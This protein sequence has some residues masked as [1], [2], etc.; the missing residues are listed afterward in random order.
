MTVRDDDRKAARDLADGVIR[1]GKAQPHERDA[2]TTLA[3]QALADD[4]TLGKTSDGMTR[5]AR[6]ALLYGSRKEVQKMAPQKRR[7]LLAHTD[8]GRAILASE[9]GKKP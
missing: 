3:A 8:T 2:L 1:S 6:V 9:D 4:R 5:A 7:E